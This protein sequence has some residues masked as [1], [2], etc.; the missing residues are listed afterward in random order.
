MKRIIIILLLAMAI[1]PATEARQ[2]LPKG[3]TVFV[4]TPEMK[5]IAQIHGCKNTIKVKK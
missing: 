4:P 1:A 5:Q 2:R 3:C